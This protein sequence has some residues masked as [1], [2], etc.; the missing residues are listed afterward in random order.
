MQRFLPPEGPVALF[1]AQCSVGRVDKAVPDLIM[2]LFSGLERRIDLLGD[3][4]KSRCPGLRVSA[5]TGLDQ[6]AQ[7]KAGKKTVSSDS[8]HILTMMV[9]PRILQKTN[10]LFPFINR[11]RRTSFPEHDAAGHFP[12]TIGKFH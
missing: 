2:K 1:Y 3:I 10:Q 7:H 12:E 4:R 11:N 6:D 5:D 8:I 9:L